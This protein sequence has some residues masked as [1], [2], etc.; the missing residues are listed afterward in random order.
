PVEIAEEEILVT[1]GERLRQAR[2]ARG[3][4]LRDV[5]A[6]TRQSQ[7]T[8]SALER[9]ETEHISPTILRMQAKSYAR[10]LGLAEEEIASAYAEARGSTNAQAMPVE[11]VRAKAPPR[12]AILAGAGALALVMLVGGGVLLLGSSNSEPEDRLAV[13]ARIST[14]DLNRTELM[15]LANET[16]PELSLRARRAAWIEVRGSDG[17]VFRSRRM[18]RGETYFPRTGAGWSITVRDAGA[19][20]WRL[21]ETVFGAVGNDDQ[22][23]YSLSVDNAYAT[24]LAAQS[25]ALADTGNTAADQR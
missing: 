16:A 4:D 10:F 22:A 8:L 24:A 20:D 14:P 6:Q 23:L 3:L 17:T 18:S 11:V 21:G 12:M 7:D 5:A 9:M 25:A 2:E 13:S 15:N 19:F 1:A